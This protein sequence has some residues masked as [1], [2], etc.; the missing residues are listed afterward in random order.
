MGSE[1]GNSIWA[2]SGARHR[3]LPSS[4]SRRSVVPRLRRNARGDGIARVHASASLRAHKGSSHAADA[5]GERN[6]PPDA[7]RPARR[8]AFRNGRAWTLL[9]DPRAVLGFCA[10]LRQ[11]RCFAERRAWSTHAGAGTGHL[12]RPGAYC[13]AR[14]E[15][16]VRGCR[17]SGGPQPF[18]GHPQSALSQAQG[19]RRLHHRVGRAFRRGRGAILRRQNPRPEHHLSVQG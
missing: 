16:P 12:R 15:L 19:L 17:Q 8:D 9:A 6:T 18:A 14:A 10:Q 13:R 2:K 7:A 1:A 5:A 3:C 4:P 11:H